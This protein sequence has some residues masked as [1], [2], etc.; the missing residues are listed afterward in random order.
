MGEVTRLGTPFRLTSLN[1]GTKAR[2]VA[3]ILRTHFKD[4]PISSI[5]LA[6]QTSLTRGQLSRVVKYMRRCSLSDLETFI[7]YYP[8]SSKKGYYYPQSWED[9]APCYFTM[10][11]WASSILKTCAP[12]EEKMRKENIDIAEHIKEAQANK[13]DEFNEY[14]YLL[15][16][17]EEINKDTSWFLDN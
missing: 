11:S 6:E 8:I 9:F 7:A 5:K 14:N 2:E 3:L 4:N 10:V 1:I 17:I 16:D 15:D 13:M 12:M